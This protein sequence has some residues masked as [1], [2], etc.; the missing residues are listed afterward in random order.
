MKVKQMA[1]KLIRPLTVAVAVAVAMTTTGVANA[2]T[3]NAPEHAL[4]NQII[5]AYQSPAG[6]Q[7]TAQLE[8]LLSDPAL[9]AAAMAL[10]QSD[11]VSGRND[12]TLFQQDL[13]KALITET[14]DPTLTAARLSGTPLSP[15]QRREERKLQAALRKNPAV[16][17]LIEAGQQLRDSNQLAPDVATVA[18]GNGTSYTTL[19]PPPTAGQGGSAALDTVI[20][21]VAALRTSPSFSGLAFDLAPVLQ[22]PG[23]VQLLEDQRP[24]D[25]ASF[26]PVQNMISLLISHD[27]DPG[28]TDIVKSSLEILGGVAA[29]GAVILLAPEELAGAALAGVVLGIVAGV[30]AVA[31]GMIDLGTALDCDLDGD[32]FD[33][34]DVPG[35]E[36]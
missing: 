22:N 27:S 28:I 6:L 19:T 7:V 29:I 26:L 13:L 34:A 31:V 17:T 32:P 9:P 10:L 23:F 14:T 12:L 1:R 30:S 8:T 33:P 16:D 11:G 2:A 3:A 36:C 4:S 25:V 5:A 24:L 18:A 15:Q 20:G 35:V 21:D